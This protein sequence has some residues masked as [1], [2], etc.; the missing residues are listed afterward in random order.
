MEK[1]F[2][3]KLT[4]LSFTAMVTPA[5]ANM[6]FISLY[7]IVDGIFVSRYV[8]E[9]ALASINIT[10]PLINVMFGVGI[11]LSTGAGALVSLHMGEGKMQQA[12]EEFSFITLVSVASGVLLMVVLMAF[13]R[14]ILLMLGAT[15]ALYEYCYIYGFIT[16]LYTPFAMFKVL[17]ENFIRADGHP[18]LSLVISVSGGVMNIVLDYI[19]IV[20]M[21]MG[22]AGAAIATMIGQVVPCILAAV[23][24]MKK[25][26]TLWFVRPKFNWHFLG[27]SCINGSSEMVTEFS[28]GFTTLLFNIF[29]L[30]ML[31]ENGLA[32]ITIILYAHFL[33]TSVYLGFS[34]GISPVVSFSYGAKNIAQLHRVMRY[35][36]V[37]LCTSAVA[38]FALGELGAQYIVGVFTG[39]DSPVFE[40]GL[41]G[42]RLFSPCFLFIGVNIF[43]SALFTALGDG[44]ISAI[45]SFMRALVF[46]VLGII[47]LPMILHSD[48]IWLTIPFAE[49]LT[50]FISLWFIK[51]YSGQYH[52]GIRELP[53][54]II[55][56]GVEPV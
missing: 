17:A 43:A 51:K 20:E 3:K 37:F 25:R 31:G 29:T 23:Y 24:F 12:R 44:K 56:I 33:L 2:S 13:L 16:V 4:P 22:I 47:V 38:V 45:I 21:S 8:G 52:L 49:F 41:H 19:F 46:V 5:I 26:G 42:M 30:R 54:Q 53:E 34:S 48:G 11:M 1:V 40:L 27:A 35:C 7:T 39:V 15:P 9:A 32:A 10:L 14:P 18:T 50:L 6:V 28:T 55:D 36:L